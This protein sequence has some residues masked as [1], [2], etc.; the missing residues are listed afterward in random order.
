[1]SARLDQIRQLL[2]EL[3]AQVDYAPDIASGR[4]FSAL[5]LPLIIQ[6]IVDDLQPLLTPYQA[7]YYWYLFRHSI[8]ENGHPVL[9]ISTRGI[10]RGVVKSSRGQAIAEG[11]ARETLASLHSLGRFARRANQTEWEPRT[12]F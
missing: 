4:D 7:V 8:T 9:R 10:R 3:E 6:Q 11:Q 5:E 1:M 2:N 12:A